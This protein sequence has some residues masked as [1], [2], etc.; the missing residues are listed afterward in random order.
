VRITLA[1]AASARHLAAFARSTCDFPIPVHIQIDTGLTRLGIDPRAAEDL[2]TLVADL[3][4]L[5]LEGLYA[6]FSHGD[7]PGH[8]TLELQSAALHRV[9]SALKKTVPHL[10]VHLQ[11]SG[12]TWHLPAAEQHHFNMVRLGI[13]LYGLQPS[14]DDP[15]PGLHPIARVT[16][17]LIALH[18]CRAGTGVGYGHTFVT[19]RAS[20]LGIVPVGYADGYPRQLSNRSIAQLRGAAVPVVGRVSMDQIV[21]DVTD[22]PLAAVGDVVQVISWN[23]SDKN[24]MDH[25]AQAV[26]TIGY[27]LATHLGARLLRK[28]VD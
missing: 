12:G 4:G 13:A 17:P 28:T 5:R 23:P 16:A 27:E 21:V 26:G 14:M 19:A 2:A 8:P 15:L 9:S 25:M 22:V 7:V 20:T 3:P 6:H 11:N 18:R 10:M 24:S 1:D